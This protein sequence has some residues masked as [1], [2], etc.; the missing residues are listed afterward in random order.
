MSTAIV[1]AK[2]SHIL[3]L[4]V[5]TYE[6]GTRNAVVLPSGSVAS[7]IELVFYDERKRLARYELR[8]ANESTSV[9]NCHAYA[10]RAG[11]D[12]SPVACAS[13]AVLPFSGVAV[14]FDLPLPFLGNYER[15][16]IEMHGD[17]IDLSSDTIPPGR[18]YRVLIRR[19]ALL[20]FAGFSSIVLALSG[21]AQ[22]RIVAVSAPSAA[23]GGSAVT[24]GYEVRGLGDV[25]YQVTAPDGATLA[26]GILHEQ[27]GSLPLHLPAVA[28]TRSYA[29]AL[30]KHTLLGADERTVYVK[31]MAT[32]SPHLFMRVIHPAAITA[33]G[34]DHSTVVAGNRITVRYGYL[35]KSGLLRLLDAQDTV[36]AATPLAPGGVA[37]FMAPTVPHPQVMRV[38]LHVEKDDTSADS[39]VGVTIVPATPAPVAFRALRGAPLQII[40][41]TLRPGMVI[42]LRVTKAVADLHLAF[43]DPH[44]LV[45]ESFNVDGDQATLH[46]PH[47]A[48]AGSYTLVISFADRNGQETVV[49]PIRIDKTASR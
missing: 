7:D 21:L 15:I 27:T 34:L 24:I 17:G 16:T 25:Q 47:D 36:W 29:L 31:A 32:P 22:P 49:V 23:L 46:I 2:V 37:Q 38:A 39:V 5:F 41:Q 44:G 20:V 4:E 1:P 9:L 28:T 12:G 43:Q 14:T 3:P 42:P 33:L 11:R 40:A 26:S 19:A 6:R 8:I 48:Q 13:V 45:I 35:A 30:S 18:D 10:V